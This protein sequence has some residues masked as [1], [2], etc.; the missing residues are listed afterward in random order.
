MIPKIIHY[1]WF[2]GGKIPSAD[3]ACIDSWKE[4]MPDYEIKCWNETNVDLHSCG[5]IRQAAEAGKWAYVSDCA[6]FMILYREGGFFLDTDVKAIKPFDDFLQEACFFG[7]ERPNFSAAPGLIIGAEPGNGV[8]REMLEG[9]EN[10][11]FI[12]PDSVKDAPTSPV[13]A[14]DIL[15]RHGFR[16]EN[17]LQRL[18][19]VTV[20]P[21]EYFAPMDYATGLVTCTEN[22]YSIHIYSSSWLSPK[23]TRWRQRRFQLNRLFGVKLGRQ[24]YLLWSLPSRLLDK[25]KAR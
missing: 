12:N 9:Y 5:Y 24:L 3:Q 23:E 7:M 4:I 19:G 6:R 18:E 21:Y 10:R 14:T 13:Y 2:G 16:Q 11:D 25:I 1:C 15:I 22:T 8:I 20:Y 17:R